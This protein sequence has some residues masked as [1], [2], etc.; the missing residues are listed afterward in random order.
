MVVMV[1]VMVLPLRRVR[2]GGVRRRM[3]LWLARPVLAMRVVGV[4]V[5]VV[6][7]LLSMMRWCM[8]R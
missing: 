4:R 1:M 8:R 6:L 2:G 7:L 5:G 3:L